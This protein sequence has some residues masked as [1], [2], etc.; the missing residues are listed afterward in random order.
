MIGQRLGF[1]VI[2]SGGV[3]LIAKRD[4]LIATV[5][6][7]LDDLRDVGLYLSD[8]VY[9]DLVTKAGEETP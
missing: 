2:G 9:W 7:L 6:P 1:L 8:R 4:S 5:R 3:L